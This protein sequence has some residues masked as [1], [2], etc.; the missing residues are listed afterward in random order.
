MGKETNGNPDAPRKRGCVPYLALLASSVAIGLVVLEVGSFL[1]F[2]SGSRAPLMVSREVD[3]GELQ[4]RDPALLFFMRPNQLDAQATWHEDREPTYF[5]TNRLG[6]RHGPVMPKGN[7]YRILTIGDSSTFGLG[8]NDPDTW[9]AQLQQLLDPSENR[10]EV[11]NAGCPGFS[12]FQ[13]L[14]FLR[15]VG[16]GLQPDL[17]IASFGYNDEKLAPFSDIDVWQ[18]RSRKGLGRLLHGTIEDTNPEGVDA[19]ELVP[20]LT[21]GEHVDALLGIHELCR[22]KDVQVVF[23]LWPGEAVLFHEHPDG[24]E[25][26]Q[27]NYYYPDLIR[28]VGKQTGSPVVNLL[29][30]QI[31]SGWDALF[32]D[33]VHPNEA[34]CQLAAEVIAADLRKHF[35]QAFK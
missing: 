26:G 18:S 20:R 3:W 34:G 12:A 32:M 13:G 29:T 35:P 31:R 6:L 2:Y 16:L 27:P 23:L 1:I 15:A 25:H 33:D 8:V 30:D 5:S 22:E 14:C 21:P 7:R 11:V 19:S 24:K 10:V 28:W 9:P 4:Q 17:V